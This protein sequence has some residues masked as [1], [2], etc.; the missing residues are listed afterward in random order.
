MSIYPARNA[1]GSSRLYDVPLLANDGANF[2]TWKYRTETVLDMR[3][4]LEIAEG[5]ATRPD[6]TVPVRVEEWERMN[7]EARSQI[8]LT[9]DDE[10]LSGVLHVKEASVVWKKICERYEGKG[11]QTIA[12]LIRDLFRSTLSDDSPL[13]P[14]LNAM[15]QK[16]FTLASLGQKSTLR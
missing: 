8:T 3:G 1:Q 12:F 10:P 9:L 16:G 11:K 5:N 15:R 4:L 6:N 14:Q 13:E 7:K 2:Q